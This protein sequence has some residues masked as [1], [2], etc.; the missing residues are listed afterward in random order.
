[1]TVWEATILG[2]IQG[3]TEFLPISSTAHLLVARQLLGHEHPEDA[4]TVVIQLGT[5]VAVFAY[6]WQDVVKLAK[7]LFADLRARHIGSTPDA[8]M[9]WL[10]VLGTV[11]VVLVGFFFKNWLKATFFNPTSIAIVAIVFALL[12]GAAEWWAVR[13]AQRGLAP[14]E[15]ADITW[16][17]AL[18]VGSFQALALMPGGSRSG[19]TITAGLFVGLGRPAAARFS[20]LLSLPAIL[21]AGLKEMFDERDRL[22]ASGDQIAALGVGLVVSAVVGY[23]SI[24]F[25][26][27]FLKRYSTAVFIVYR[28]LLGVTILG[29]LAIGVLK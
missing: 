6:F 14:R 4:F 22:F 16:L 2:V 18:W 17:D 20:F 10:I 27:N 25:L 13:R 28:L 21:G 19:T 15:E 1:M 24:A 12:M 26:L 5:L 8:R 9:G 3:L 29:L 23:L 11:P 7:G